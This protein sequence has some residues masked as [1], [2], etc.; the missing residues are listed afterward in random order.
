MDVFHSCYVYPKALLNGA[1]SLGF[2]IAR[3]P[4]NYGL[5]NNYSLEP[6]KD[7]VKSYPAQT[8]FGE[9]VVYQD[10]CE[11]GPEIARVPLRDP[12]NS[13]NRQNLQTP[14]GPAVGEHDLCLIFT[15]P[16]EGPWYVIDSVKL[17]RH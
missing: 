17:L 9:L 16:T 2:D 13:D 5:A 6:A 12:A 3:L 7:Q 15:A 11:T 1:R 14:I 4:R 10:Q 8:P